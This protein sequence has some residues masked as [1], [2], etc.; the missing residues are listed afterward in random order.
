MTP[1][2][3]TAGRR[4][5][6]S[7]PSESNTPPPDRHRTRPIRMFTPR[8]VASLRAELPKDE[9]WMVAAYGD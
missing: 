8:T 6:P 3:R 2:T 7:R 9:R 5:R 1:S 4:R